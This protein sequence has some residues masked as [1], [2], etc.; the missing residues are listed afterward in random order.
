MPKIKDVK[1]HKELKLDQFK[2]VVSLFL[3]GV[4]DFGSQR[5]GARY[6]GVSNRTIVDYLNKYP[7]FKEEYLE[8]QQ[9]YIGTLEEIASMRSKK[10]SDGLLNRQLVAYDP[11]RYAKGPETV[12]Q[13]NN[14]YNIEA[15]QAIR[16][17]GI[18]AK[19]LRL[20][21]KQILN[22]AQIDQM[23]NKE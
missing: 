2:K 3:Q 9:Y 4:R 20:E 23:K 15:G 18:A 8:A 19:Q 14:T 21:R 16:T 1:R 10:Y 13:N 12:I 5:A 6:A 7:K 11:G 22:V 17:A